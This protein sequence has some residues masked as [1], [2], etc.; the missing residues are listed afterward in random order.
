MRVYLDTVI[1][2]Y[3][4]EGLPSFQSRAQDHL[5]A[6]TAA[7][8]RVAVSDLTRLECRIKPVRLR[9]AALLA[10][11]DTF[12]DAGTVA[13]VP[14]TSAVYDLA[15]HIRAVHRFG[16]ADSLHLAAALESGCGAFL[17]NDAR[18]AR[19]PDLPVQVLA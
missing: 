9:D 3:L 12:L 6:L 13:K 7:G 1:V 8:H 16:L 14:L 5:A 11:F 4:V 17:T 19:F 2:I 18:L 15:T 10:D